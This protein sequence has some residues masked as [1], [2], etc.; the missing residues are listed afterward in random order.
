ME[1]GGFPKTDTG[2]P[3][4]EAGVGGTTEGSNEIVV[5]VGL[6]TESPS[7]DP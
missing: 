7:V 3:A 2:S 4:V 6:A 1:T 5:A